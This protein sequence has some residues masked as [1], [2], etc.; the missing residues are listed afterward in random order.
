MAE[1]RAPRS[2]DALAAVVAVSITPLAGIVFLGW[3]PAGVLISYF[4]DTFVGACAVMMLLMIHVTGDELD[5]PVEGWKRWG[6]LVGAFVFMSAIIALPLALPL[7]FMLGADVVTTTLLDDRGF[8]LGLAVQ[9]LMSVLAAMRVHRKLHTTH[10]DDRILSVRGLFLAARCMVVFIAVA[11]G[12]VPALGPRIGSFVLIAI[13][14]GATVYF[15]LFPEHA[16]RFV[17][18]AKAGPIQ[19]QRDLESRARERA[20]IKPR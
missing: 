11:T 15:E 1:A 8:M 18:G 16:T 3:Q 14:A 13:Y 10:D 9:V 4:V 19:Y 6:K 2:P 5:T 12:L 17:R 20:D 7:L